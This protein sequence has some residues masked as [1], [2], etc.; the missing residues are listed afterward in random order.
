MALVLATARTLGSF[1]AVSSHGPAALRQRVRLIRR[2]IRDPATGRLVCVWEPDPE[3]RSSGPLPTVLGGL[4][5]RHPMGR[6]RDRNWRATA[7]QEKRAA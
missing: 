3:D 5:R 7:S 6:R 2:W 1:S 4:A